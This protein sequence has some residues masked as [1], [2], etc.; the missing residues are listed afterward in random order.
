MPEPVEDCVESVLED[1]PEYSE[2]RAYAIC[3]AQQNKGNLGLED[4]SHDELLHAQAELTDECDSGY[5]K[6]DGECVKV[7][8]VTDVPP[9]ALHNASVYQ[10]AG[11]E[12]EPIEREELGDN[13]VAYRNLKILQSGIWQDSSSRESIWYSPRGLENME[14]TDDNAVNIMHDDDNDVSTAGHLENLRAEDG[15]LFA[16]VIIDT[17]NSAGSYAD[18]NLQK[19]LETEG[20]KGFGGPSV[21]IPPEG[22]EMEYNS[23]KGVKELMA[24]LID[25]LG[26]VR[27]PASKPTSFAR[28][29][30]ARG[31]ALSESDQTVMELRGEQ[32]SMNPEEAREIL[33]KFGFDTGDMDDEDVVDMLKDMGEEI[34]D[35]MDEGESEGEGED[36]EGE[37]ME[38][39][40]NEGENPDDEPPEEEEE[41][42][43]DMEDKVQSLEERL[44]NVEDMVESAMMSEDLADA[45]SELADAETVTELQEQKEEIEKRLSEL[46]DQSEKPRSLSE[47]AS[48]G[49]E[50]EIEGN[51][52]YAGEYDSV[53]GAYSR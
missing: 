10:L 16:D 4:P 41:D 24:G 53:R 30:A 3:H 32:E 11:L 37:E 5:V 23:E 40:E 26:L 51:V 20:A 1:H 52:T 31:V 6:A 2:S 28:Q 14:L 8:D 39:D 19:T 44:Q 12:T 25:G 36:G 9:S 34:S 35:Y 21:E 27:N 7:E 13:Q 48:E 15:S 50:E 49:E 47:G 38:D 43:M 22:Q 29:S 42:E 33:E 18:E 46:E 17:S 45:K